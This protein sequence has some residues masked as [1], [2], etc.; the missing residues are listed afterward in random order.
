MAHQTIP[1]E[2]K[3]LAHQTIP[4]D[5]QTLLL[6]KPFNRRL[7]NIKAVYIM[8]F[9]HFPFWD[10]KTQTP[11]SHLILPPTTC[12]FAAFT[13]QFSSWYF[14]GADFSV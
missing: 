3:N 8:Y 10:D 11:F 2:D 14:L 9:G 7:N 5:D 13:V 1:L 6:I 4:L 12:C